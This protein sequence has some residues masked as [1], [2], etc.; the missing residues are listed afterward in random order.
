MGSLS[1]RSFLALSVGVVLGA[2][3]SGDDAAAPDAQPDGTAGAPPDPTD[4][5]STVP[6]TTTPATTTAAGTTTTAAPLA[7]DPF[8]LGVASGDPEPA[9]VILW[10]R[11]LGAD[12]PTEVPVAYELA[13]DEGFAEIVVAQE[14]VAR[15]DEGHSV[16]AAPSDLDADTWYW[17]RFTAGGYTSPTGRTRTLP[18]DGDLPARFVVGSASCQ[19]YTDGFYAAHLDIAAAGLDC[20]FWLG[21][22]IYEGA[23]EPVGGANVRSHETPEPVTLDDYRARYAL[24]KSDPALQAAHAS[25]PWV[26]TWDDHEVENNY[27][28]AVS[29]DAVPTEEFL[30]RRAAAYRAW[31]EHQP[32][33]LAAPTGADYP[34]HR[35]VRVGGLAD[36][37]VLDTRQ[38]R[39][40]QACGDVTLSLDPA[41]AENADTAR[42]MLG[43]EQEAWLFDRLGATTAVW[44]VLAQ[45]VIMANAS[46]GDAV[47]NYDQWDGYPAAR[48]RLLGMIAELTVPNL[49]V[50]TGDIHF[51]GVGKIV[52]PADPMAPPLGTEFV[53]TSISSSGNVPASLE[54]LV[55]TL[56]DVVD[57]ELAHRGWTKHTVTP[58]DWTAEYRIVADAAVA[59]SPS[60]T[61][62]SFRI[63]AGTPSVVPV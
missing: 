52:D 8:G 56:G 40:D 25:C 38:Y 58:T 15:A 3:S 26:V 24:Y 41:C 45:Q 21:D 29:Q 37:S 16:H 44:N 12:L 9:S 59:D 49:V 43:D 5:P 13:L 19:N 27:A 32:V 14:L 10:T 39:A 11:L 1:R 7:S 28:G 62:K 57:V 47:L 36:F 50:L 35:G 51:A 30:A 2:C 22:Y 20:L 17:F 63:T 61:W 4:G 42:T 53:D 18:A 54:S 60:S 55:A 6:T 31:W 48:A 34:I 23:A 33:R 46:F